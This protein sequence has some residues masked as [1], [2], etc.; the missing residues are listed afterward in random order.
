MAPGKKRFPKAEKK[1]SISLDLKTV[2]KTKRE[3][4]K[5]HTT[6]G[7][8]KGVK[9]VPT[10]NNVEQPSAGTLYRCRYPGGCTYET[11]SKEEI[12]EH[13]R[14]VHKK[15][16]SY[17]CEECGQEFIDAREL[18]YESEGFYPNFIRYH[19][20]KVHNKPYTIQNTTGKVTCRWKE[21]EG[22][23]ECG[24][25][26]ADKKELKQHKEKEGKL[27]A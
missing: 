25:T 4:K 11:W 3:E 22:S 16:N 17:S 14:K 1:E 6:N 2:S 7:K 26:F 12:M 23:P 20:E 5:K 27:S 8:S 9:E 19:V 13:N 21:D 15:G 10:K 24:K 18:K